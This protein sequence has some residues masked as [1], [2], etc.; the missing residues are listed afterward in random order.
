MRRTLSLLSMGLQM[1]A[2]NAAFISASASSCEILLD[3]NL[4]LQPSQIPMGGRGGFTILS[5]RFCI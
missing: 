4:E 1:W 2:S 5:L 3:L